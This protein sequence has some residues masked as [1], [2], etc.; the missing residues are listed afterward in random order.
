MKLSII[1]FIF[2]SLLSFSYEDDN[3]KKKQCL[4]QYTIC[5]IKCTCF[6]KIRPQCMKR[7]SESYMQ[8]MK[9][10]FILK[11]YKEKNKKI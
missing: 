8:C 5:L 7:C 6:V 2:L 10:I 3:D 9:N 11:G 4:D 1:L